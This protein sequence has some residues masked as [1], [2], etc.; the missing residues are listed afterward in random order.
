MDAS[1]EVSDPSDWLKTPI[2]QLAAV[3]AAL[4]C[5]VCKDFFDTPMITSCSHTFCSLC[6]RRCLTNDGKCPTCRTADQ[7]LR[8]RRNWA[9]EET[10][11]AFKDARPA[12]ISFSE[13]LQV[14]KEQTEH[15][16]SKR[17]IEE[18][19]GQDDTTKVELGTSKR[20]TRSQNRRSPERRPGMRRQIQD[21]EDDENHQD[22]TSSR[23]FVEEPA[24]C[25]PDDGLT[26][27]PICNKRMKEEEVFPHLDVHNEPAR[28][29][30]GRSNG[31]RFVL[32][33]CY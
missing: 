28:S 1:F 3:E 30:S 15:R 13:K 24:K 8:L 20:K 26:A 31:I 25:W 5:Q 7:E 27:C 17:K 4:R 29:T 23:Y 11:Q 33:A 2:K 12:L 32:H 22:S 19:N 21:S 14:A 9:L 18:V 6:I 16:G 10:V